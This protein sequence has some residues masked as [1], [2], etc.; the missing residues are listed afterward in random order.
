MKRTAGLAALAV[1]TVAGLAP[2]TALSPGRALASTATA[3][4]RAPLWVTHQYVLKGG[5]NGQVAASPNGSAVFVAGQIATG[6]A[7]ADAMLWDYNQA[8]GAPLWHE[9]Y[10]AARQSWFSAV[11]VSPDGATV[12][13][14]GAAQATS[15]SPANYLTVAYNAA[16]GATVWADP[17]GP[18]GRA[19]AIALSPDGS[20]VF[21]TGAT[22]TVAYSAAT[23]ATLWT[24]SA[25]ASAIAVAP[26][27]SAVYVASSLPFGFHNQY[28]AYL[29]IAYNA[30]TGATLWSRQFDVPKGRST[31]T[32][33]AASPSG[34]AVVV[35]G[36]TFSSVGGAGNF[37]TVAYNPV[38]GARM[39]VRSYHSSSGSGQARSIAI[40]PDGSKVFVTGSAGASGLFYG[41]YATLAY[42]TAAGT[43]LWT[44]RYRGPASGN[45]SVAWDLAVSPDGAKVFVTGYSF[46]ATQ[47]GQPQFATVAYAAATGTQLWAGRFGSPATE[48]CYGMSVAASPDSSKVFVT[49]DCAAA[50]ATVAYHS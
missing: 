23:G 47:L 11:A 39:W 25:G 38:T 8:T 32:A 26:G 5:V 40:S 44:A 31:A 7:I 17:A 21:V 35:T 14:T 36:V 42:N 12:F 19:D 27:G 49:G 18:Q 46:S 9:R 29:T 3:A 34:N 45:G 20:A 28:N 50:G 4:A 16:T 43:P 10:T 13:A 15:S 1:L 33:I 37:G 30:A 6:P 22:G 24:A 41:Y 48:A 2:A